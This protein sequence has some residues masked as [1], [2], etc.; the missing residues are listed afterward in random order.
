GEGAALVGVDID[1]RCR[2]FSEDGIDI[3][4]GDQSDPLLWRRIIDKYTDFDV[5]IDDGSHIADHQRASFLSLWPHL[6]DGGTYIIEDCHTSY[7]QEYGGG[8]RT[9]NGFI[10]FAKNRIDDMNALWSPDPKKLAP[11][12]FTLE[13]GAIHFYDSMVVFEKKRQAT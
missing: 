12:G 10:D 2:E 4:I 1:P 3:E 6:R 8:I 11:S 5:I 9:G 13:I 7:W